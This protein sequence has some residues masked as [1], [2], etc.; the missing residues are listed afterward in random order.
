MENNIRWNG[1]FYSNYPSEDEYYYTGN[2]YAFIMPN[3]IGNKFGY[4][5]DLRKS[6]FSKSREYSINIKIRIQPKE[7]E[8]TEL[9]NFKTKIGAKIAVFKAI[10]EFEKNPE[11]IKK[12]WKEIIS[13]KNRIPL[14]REYDDGGFEWFATTFLN[15]CYWDAYKDIEQ[16]S[17]HYHNRGIFWSFKKDWEN[18]EERKWSRTERSSSTM[19]S[20]GIIKTP[21]RLIDIEEIILGILNGDDFSYQRYIHEVM[22]NR[23]HQ[24]VQNQEFEPVL[25]F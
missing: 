25:A 16:N 4:R 7:I 2:D 6:A 15:N 3:I 20:G 13:Y 5:V 1:E 9:N 10:R 8:I 18:S 11:N 24:Q 21:I 17:L 19:S 23:N 22:R 12:I 14:I